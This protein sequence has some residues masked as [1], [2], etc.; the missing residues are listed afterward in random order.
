MPVSDEGAAL[1]FFVE[2]MKA[3]TAALQGV[4]KTMQGIQEEQ[5]ETLRLVHDTRERVIR[6]ESG[7]QGD[8]IIQLQNK[9]EAV[10]TRIDE[11]ERARDRNAGALN[12]SNWLL[13]NGPTLLALVGVIFLVLR[14][15][16]KL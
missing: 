11:L 13:Q 6:I 2:A 4:G 9:F 8:Q 1:Q 5:K 7:G 10:L 15:G 12:M 16:G 14:A 3:N